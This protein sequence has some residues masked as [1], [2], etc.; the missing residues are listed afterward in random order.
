MVGPEKDLAREDF[1][2]ARRLRDRLVDIIYRLRDARLRG[3]FLDELRKLSQEYGVPE[4]TIRRLAEL[5]RVWSRAIE[6]ER[7]A[8]RVEM[9]VLG[10]LDLP[11]M[12][13][14]IDLEKLKRALELLKKAERS[15]AE[16]IEL[17]SLLGE[18]RRGG[19]RG[20]RAWLERT[21]LPEE[22]K[23]GEGL[24]L[25]GGLGPMA[26]VLSMV[27]VDRWLKYFEVGLVPRDA[28]WEGHLSYAPVFLQ[29]YLEGG[30]L[31]VHTVQANLYS[32]G[33]LRRLDAERLLGEWPRLLIRLAERVAEA[34]GVS[35]VE[36]AGPLLPYLRWS[37][38]TDL[39]DRH[40]EHIYVLTPE[41]EGYRYNREKGV[42][43]KEI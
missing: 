34:L 5:D 19:L 30:T 25:R 6:S 43:E 33:S 4:D 31:V 2:V 10:E 41:Q 22:I 14:K 9:W 16:E 35:R 38:W 26:V 18:T 23:W 28:L 1:N 24:K 17:R 36:I 11:E 32:P 15:E 39:E 40:M 7:A 27:P 12:K 42:W 37:S 13:L 3:M 21:G 20:I 29:G 8:G